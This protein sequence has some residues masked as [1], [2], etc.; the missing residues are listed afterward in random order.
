MGGR[1]E[2]GAS[3]NAFVLRSRDH[4]YI[5]Y[6]HVAD[7]NLLRECR[8]GIAICGEACLGMAA[9]GLVVGDSQDK[10]VSGVSE[11]II[12]TLFCFY[13]CETFRPSRV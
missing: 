5:R 10:L 8:E 6:G 12:L 7:K 3:S 4:V 13:V 11:W 1:G 2:W 9:S